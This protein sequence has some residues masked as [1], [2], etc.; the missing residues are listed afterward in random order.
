MRRITIVAAALAVAVT[1]TACVNQEQ[2]DTI[3]AQIEESRQAIAEER[4]DLTARLDAIEPTPEN[5]QQIDDLETRVNHLETADA[6]LEQA[7]NTIDRG[8]QTGYVNEVAQYV[9]PFLPPGAREWVLVAATGL[10]LL[11]RLRRKSQGLNSL[12]KSVVRL[13]DDPIIKSAIDSNAEMLRRI[14]SPQAKKAID[15]AQG[16]GTVMP[17]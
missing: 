12:A 3:S 9:Q 17:L 16:S 14:Q 10:G 6:T 8:S 11:E 7:E 2:I 13:A 1:F 5:A 15:A 4:A